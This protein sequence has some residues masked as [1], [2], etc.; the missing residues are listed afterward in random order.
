MQFHITAFNSRVFVLFYSPAENR[1]KCLDPA[2]A[3]AKRN[4]TAEKPRD[5]NFD[6]V[7]YLLTLR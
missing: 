5:G 6:R 4:H 7:I 3:C 2:S 1:E